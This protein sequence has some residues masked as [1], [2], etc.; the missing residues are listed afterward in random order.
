MS[1]ETSV[2][3]SAE[4]GERIYLG[5]RIINFMGPEGCG[6]TVI[7]KR[8]AVESGMPRVVFGDIFRDL[9]ANDPGPYGDEC[10]VMFAEHRYMKPEILAQII[11]DIFRQ[12]ELAN[13]FIIDGGMRTI[14][15]IKNFN[16][17]LKE[18][19]RMMPVTSVL[20]RVPGWM[21][22]ERILK[23]AGARNRPIEDSLNGTLGRL[24]KYY[25]R[26]GRRTSLIQK[27]RG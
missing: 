2:G 6:K 25:K 18:A 7:S 23:A 8:L 20:L 11:P 1:V 21:G 3:T 4:L 24:S 15:E 9:A 10:R 17:M 12:A 13:G 5:R 22:V 27:K 19:E 16:K 14:G 26:L